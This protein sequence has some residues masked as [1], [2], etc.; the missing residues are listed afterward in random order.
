MFNNI[1]DVEAIRR[2]NPA[3]QDRRMSSTPS[4]CSSS[5]RT[6]CPDP[7]GFPISSPPQLTMAKSPHLFS[8][9]NDLLQTQ[10]RKDDDGTIKDGGS[11]HITQS[12]PRASTAD[13]GNTMV[14]ELMMSPPRQR[15]R[16]VSEEDSFLI[17]PLG[18]VAS[19]PSYASPAEK[20]SKAANLGPLTQSDIL[21]Q[22][23]SP[24]PLK[25]SANNFVEE[26]SDTQLPWTYHGENERGLSSVPQPKVEDKSEPCDDIY[27]VSGNSQSPSLQEESIINCRNTNTI[28]D[29]IG[30]VKLDPLEQD[31]ILKKVLSEIDLKADR[32][33]E[34]R[35]LA[36]S[37]TARNQGRQSPFQGSPHLSS[38]TLVSEATG[39]VSSK[40]GEE[41]S[42]GQ[43]FKITNE[44]LTVKESRDTINEKDGEVSSNLDIAIKSNDICSDQRKSQS[45][46]IDILSGETV[47]GEDN[48]D[49]CGS[50][51]FGN[52]LG[53]MTGWSSEIDPKLNPQKVKEKEDSSRS[54]FFSKYSTLI[55]V[56]NSFFYF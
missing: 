13:L 4:D 34:A 16:R 52:S 48:E 31:A 1:C 53:S 54:K 28:S 49:E 42:K 33:R 5:S 20:W 26:L 3:A 46:D 56:H 23:R 14:K 47:L 30:T 25:T 37:W 2:A 43:Q 6:S 17:S 36:D 41:F 38:N 18:S 24:S 19:P 9:P 21:K 40:A 51:R 32:D 39:E 11:P 35:D 10:A 50:G 8:R 29:D 7:S 55:G 44:D 15:S 12:S 27:A 45:V 22:S